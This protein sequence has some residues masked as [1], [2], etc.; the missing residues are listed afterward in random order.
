MY[1]IQ[2]SP[3]TSFSETESFV[4]RIAYL[5]IWNRFL[6]PHE[7]IEYYTT[8]EP[9]QGDLYSWSDFKN[10]IKGNVKV[11]EE[12]ALIFRDANAKWS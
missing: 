5:D 1:D 8:C 7:I 9:Y 3:G 11:W 2:D 12:L 6:R 10:K 4:G